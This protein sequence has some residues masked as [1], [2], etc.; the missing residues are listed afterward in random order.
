MAPTSFPRTVALA[1]TL[2]LGATVAGSGAAFAA[3]TNVDFTKAVP[4]ASDIAGASKDTFTVPAVAGVANYIAK[5]TGGTNGGR[6]IVY[7]PSTSKVPTLGATKVELTPVAKAG[8]AI[9]AEQAT[10]TLSFDATPTTVTVATAPKA[11]DKAGRTGDRVVITP[12]ANVTWTVNGKAVSVTGTKPV[13]VPVPATAYAAGNVG[14]TVTVKAV[15]VSIDYAV[16]SSTDLKFA[17]KA[18]I[19]AADIAGALKGVDK[20]GVSKDAVEISYV[21]GV[22]WKVNGK[23]VSVPAPSTKTPAPKVTV[24]VGA[25]AKIEAV[26]AKPADYVFADGAKTTFTRADLTD[27]KDVRT[28][29]APAQ[30]VAV[31]APLISKDTLTLRGATGIYWEVVSGPADNRVAKTYT[32]ADAKT[33]KVPAGENPVV[34]AKPVTI[35]KT[36]AT[37][38]AVQGTASWNAAALTITSDKGIVAA[39]TAPVKKDDKDGTSKDTVTLTGKTGVAYVVGTSLTDKKAK[40]YT[41]K[42][43]ATQVVPVP[44][45]ASVFA[46]VT[47]AKE[48]EFAASATTSWDRTALGLADTKRDLTI[49]TA[50]QGVDLPGVADKLTITGVDGVQWKINGKSIVKVAAG[51][52][53]TVAGRS[54]E[55]LPI[56][57]TDDAIPGKATWTATELILTDAD[58]AI[59]FPEAAK[60]VGTDATGNTK[61]TVKLTGV[62]NVSYSV[63]AKKFAVAAG[64]TL[65]VPARATDT[66]TAVA[67]KGYALPETKWT[68]SAVGLLDNPAKVAIVAPKF[69]DVAGKLKDTVTITP[70]A[71]IDWFINGVKVTATKATD[72]STKGVEAVKIE[73]KGK[74]ADYAPDGGTSVWN[75]TFVITKGELAPAAPV[76]DTDAHAVKLTQMPGVIWKIDGVAVK[77]PTKVT[78]VPVAATK[79]KVVVTAVPEN[80]A[81]AEVTQ[82]NETALTF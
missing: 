31:D 8:Y 72:I 66:I 74:T 17:D 63:G 38:Y 24:V 21:P 71:N 50:P 60:P 11:E 77:V 82:N 51:K 70:A 12:V 79:T 26:V 45:G 69:N 3:D 34:T 67:A 10:I 65:V 25:D 19:K 68:G 75:E 62:A 1:V 59:T 56:N 33:Q 28:D 54:I 9:P 78:Y 43:A 76:A 40:R 64:K 48:Y 57:A 35:G 27:I 73:A 13:S 61:D 41:S 5:S 7:T 49:T 15:P 36:T 46:V 2:A 44:A 32:I 53:S 37:D 52:T 6:T 29:V 58:V 81:D 4:T 47:N 16:D 22:S 42:D 30:P 23:T 80:P 14:A 20:G 18:E 55:A 39:P